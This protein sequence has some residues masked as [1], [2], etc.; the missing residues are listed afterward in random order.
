MD[1]EVDKTR[2]G[3][4]AY[5]NND[6]ATSGLV[7]NPLELQQKNVDNKIINKKAKLMHN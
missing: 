4:Y 5:L 7:F 1:V 6:S 3:T 2:G